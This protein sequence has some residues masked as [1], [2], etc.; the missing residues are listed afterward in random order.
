MAGLVLSRRR[1][2]NCERTSFRLA[3][4]ITARS[5][6]HQSN[7]TALSSAR[8]LVL[9]HYLKIRLGIPIAQQIRRDELVAKHHETL[10]PAVT[11]VLP[12]LTTAWERLWLHTRTGEVVDCETQRNSICKHV[13]VLRTLGDSASA[14]SST[15]ANESYHEESAARGR[16]EARLSSRC[17]IWLVFDSIVRMHQTNTTLHLG[18]KSGSVSRQ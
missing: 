2:L 18:W 10:L 1:I 5:A 17:N 12:S 8:N 3:D 7:A 14:R 15:D 9:E 6:D 4:L 13:E 11:A 16:A